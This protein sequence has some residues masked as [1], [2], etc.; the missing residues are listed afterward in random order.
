MKLN[1]KTKNSIIFAN[2]LAYYLLSYFAIFT[3]Q[4]FTTGLTS[5]AFDIPV[6][7]FNNRIGFNVKPDAWTFDSVK[8]IFSSAN[9]V[10]FLLSITFLVIYLKALEF[11][12]ML[13]LFFL[14]GFVQSISTLIG[15]AIIGAFSFEGFGIVMSYLYLQDTAKMI[16]LF[17]G[18]FL[19]LAIGMMMVKPIL[20]SAN[21][22][23]QSLIPEV[24][25]TFRMVQFVLPFLIGN[26]VILAFKYPTSL[27]ETLIL[28]IPVFVLFPLFW[29]IKTYPTF[30]F[31]EMPKK[32]ILNYRVLILTILFIII[33]RFVF[34]RGINL[35]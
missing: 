9:L 32:I 14:W 16:I 13:R 25:P 28:F 2:S 17:F 1:I 5:V 20:F 34:G 31:E 12:G 10:L 21:I 18:I 22:Y 7:L 3:I 23:F 24:R 30:Y 11:D 29:G 8:V 4:Q 33:L 15:S 19:L 26:T 35:G 6:S 27:Y